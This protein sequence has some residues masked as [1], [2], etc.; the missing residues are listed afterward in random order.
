MDLSIIIINYNTNHYT[1]E[2]IKS[3]YAQTKKINIEIILIDNHSQ[4][5][6]PKAIIK[7]F[8]DVILIQ[9]TVNVGFG[10]ANNQG[11]ELAKGRYIL[12]LNSDTLVLNNALEK[13]MNFME[14]KFAIDNNIGLMGCTLLNEDNSFQNSTFEKANIWG[15]VIN[16]NPILNKLFVKSTN[17]L[18]NFNKAQF[19][20]GVSGAFMLFREDVF[21]KI[22]PFDPDIFMY[23]EETELCRNRVSKHFKSYYWPSAQVM[24]Y[25]GKS[26][27]SEIMHQQNM[28]SYALTWYKIGYMHYLVYLSFT[29]FHF[30][31]FLITY[32]FISNKQV[33]KKMLTAYS[34][35]SSQ[36]LFDIPRFNRNWGSRISPLKLSALKS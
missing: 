26:G 6:D 14:S 19:V 11:I 13:S 20:E 34:K 22:D 24:H 15:Y 8:P 29:L 2:C 36:L 18:F 35:I 28:L 3:I 31:S 33:H 25:G 16:S 32:P 23:S 27:M 30:M 21:K 5:E 7:S 4:K 12:L 9:N 10:I 17:N 1:K